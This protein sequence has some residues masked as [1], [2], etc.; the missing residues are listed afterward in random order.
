MD[1][2]HEGPTAPS[3]VDRTDPE[4][5]SVKVNPWRLCSVTQVEEIK[6]LVR[7]MPIWIFSLMFMVHVTQLTSFFLLQSTSLDRSMGPH[8]KIPAASMT[9]FN[10]L[11]AIVSIPLYGEKLQLSKPH[12]LHRRDKLCRDRKDSFCGYDGNILAQQ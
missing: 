10:S 1:L 5:S 2:E 12:L 6:L 9:I 4:K 7:V 8:F 3:Q 11:T